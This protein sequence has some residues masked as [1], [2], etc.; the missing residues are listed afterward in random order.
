MGAL[1]KERSKVS[2]KKGREGGKWRD[3]ARMRKAGGEKS[4]FSNKEVGRWR[5][6]FCS[7][8]FFPFPFVPFFFSF[9][10]FFLFPFSPFPRLCFLL[11]D[12]DL[13]FCISKP[14]HWP[15]T[16][17]TCRALPVCH[18]SLSQRPS[19]P[20]SPFYSLRHTFLHVTGANSCL[21]RCCD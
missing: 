3:F 11:V 21:G 19:L 6:D 13:H 7:S 8:S 5:N 10:F 14:C 12:Q 15:G 18:F 17:P 1:G 4:D 20:R 16:I 2:R 9:F